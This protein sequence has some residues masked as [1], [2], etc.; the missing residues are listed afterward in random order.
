MLGQIFSI[1]L[2]RASFRMATPL[3]LSALGGAMTLHA[4]TINI[5]LEGM[6]LAG[7]FFAIVGSYYFSSALVGLLLGI[8]AAALIGLIYAVFVVDL[9]A[10]TFVIGIALNM[11][12]QGGTVYLLRQMFGVKGAFA[13]PRI[14]TLP[15]VSFS[16]L[17]DCNILK[18]LFSDYTVLVYIAFLLVVL[19]MI[20]FYKTAF[21]LRLRAAGEHQTALDTVGVSTR[22]V[23]YIAY[24]G[25]GV[26]CGL[27]GTHLSL[28]Y[29][30]QFTE[31]MVAGNGFIALAATMFGQGNPARVLIAC[32]LF[33]AANAIGIRLQGVGFP[34]EFTLM[35]PYVMTILA[36]WIVSKQQFKKETQV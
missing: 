18:Q 11:L 24:I 9:K 25:S 6:M 17:D 28:G 15:K 16:F 7:A 21:G 27:A 1:S 30:N 26:L 35:I 3:I 19:C 22:K 36:L 34:S 32:L 12:M 4:G 2:L 10:D 5:A 23:Q 29:L 14:Q 31:N 8:L 20:L 33:G 13:S